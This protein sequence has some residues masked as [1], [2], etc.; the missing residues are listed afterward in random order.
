MSAVK[1]K[2]QLPEFNQDEEDKSWFERTKVRSA[3]A[4]LI[5]FATG[6]V[7][8][9]LEAPRNNACMR[10]HGSRT[11]TNGGSHFP[12]LFCSDECEQEFVRIALAG[13]TL[14]DCIRIQ[15]RLDALL[16]GID[17]AVV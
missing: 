7:D 12:D 15:R 14:Q 11:Q 4:T 2:S 1:S 3:G 13:L 10:C 8:A 16:S 9:E 5:E 6:L 17:G